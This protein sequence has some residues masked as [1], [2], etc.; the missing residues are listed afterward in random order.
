M[1]YTLHDLDHLEQQFQSP[2][3]IAMLRIQCLDNDDA[4]GDDDQQLGVAAMFVPLL[5]QTFEDWYCTNRKEAKTNVETSSTINLMRTLKLYVSLA[6]KDTVL[7][8]EVAY[9]G[10]H[11]CLSTFMKYVASI[12]WPIDTEE[13]D[14]VMEMNDWACE[15]TALSNSGKFP[16]PISPYSP[17][18]LRSRLPKSISFPFINTVGA[19]EDEH[20]ILIQQVTSRQSAQE[21]VG[22]VLWPSAVALS[23][24][25]VSNHLSIL[26]K[27]SSILELGAGTGLVGLLAAHLTERM[28]LA[29]DSHTTEQIRQVILTDFNPTVLANLKRNIELNGLKQTAVVKKLDFYQQTGDREYWVAEDESIREPQV[30]LAADM[31]CQPSDAVAAAKSIQDALKPTGQAVVICADAKHRFGVDIFEKECQRAGLHV[32]TSPVDVKATE[33]MIQTAGFVDDMRLTMFLIQKT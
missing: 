6:Q 12:T 26:R 31:I 8:E 27:A 2:R 1:T 17:D 18:D 22:F 7:A 11:I 32:T 14:T 15:I 10:G 30:D 13:T 19:T 4:T 21:D 33:N 24:W 20:T 25:L 9:E 29:N 28:S 23:E 3:N 5:Q 16:V